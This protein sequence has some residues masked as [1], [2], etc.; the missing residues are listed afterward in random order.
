MSW[1]VY[2]SGRRGEGAGTLSGPAA[3][4]HG[5]WDAPATRKQVEW[6]RD[7]GV[8]DEFLR[9]A[10]KRSASAM[11]ETKLKERGR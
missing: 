2:R 10:T 4:K 9:A 3:S 11:I 5:K 1:Q 8:S 6:L 7:L